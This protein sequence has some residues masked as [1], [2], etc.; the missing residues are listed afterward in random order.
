VHRPGHDRLAEGMNGRNGFLALEHGL[1]GKST[2]AVYRRR[3]CVLKLYGG[4]ECRAQQGL[5]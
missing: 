3:G 1:A 2:F 4:K 5:V